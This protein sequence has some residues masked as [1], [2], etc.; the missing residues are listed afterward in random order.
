MRVLAIAVLV[1]CSASLYVVLTVGVEV[2]QVTASSAA[3]PPPPPSTVA[4][5]SASSTMVTRLG[6]PVG[7]RFPDPCTSRWGTLRAARQNWP[8]TRCREPA[9]S[10]R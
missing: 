5:D 10:S 2:D 1:L 4:L 3:V 6:S 8:T 9:W 7:R